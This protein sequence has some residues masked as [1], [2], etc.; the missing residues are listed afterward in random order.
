M[1]RKK[2]DR[3]NKREQ[4]RL[5]TPY[6]QRVRESKRSESAKAR[7]K[8]L[9]QRPE[10]KE[11]ERL[12]AIEY[13]KRPHV[14]AKNNA[15]YAVNQAI[16]KGKIKRPENCENC[17]AEDNPLR[18]GRSGLRADHYLGY[19]KENHLKVRFICVSCDGKQLRKDY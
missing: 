4:R 5:N 10:Q 17:G 6:A 9:R 2:K 16:A 19:E 13:R 11:K 12:Y 3:E 1:D 15:R 8:E 7:R 18:D 14:K